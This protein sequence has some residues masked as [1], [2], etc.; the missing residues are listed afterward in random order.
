MAWARTTLLLPL[1]G[2]PS[3]YRNIFTGEKH[4]PTRENGR[5]ILRVAPLLHEFP[6]A[7][8][9]SQEED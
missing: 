6:V 8:L 2:T 3:G 7:L 4:R 1:G 9:Y 5:D